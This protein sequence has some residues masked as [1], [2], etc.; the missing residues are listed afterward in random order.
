MQ[1]LQREDY[2][3]KTKVQKKNDLKL[4]NNIHASNYLERFIDHSI[5]Q[6]FRLGGKMRSAYE[7]I[8]S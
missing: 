2:N 7:E 6:Y 1:T 5:F 3:K 4:Y 8:R